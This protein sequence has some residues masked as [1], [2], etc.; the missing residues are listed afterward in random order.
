MASTAGSVTPSGAEPGRS[1]R[2]ML[3]G[4][5]V[6]FWDFDGVIKESV[7]IKSDAFERLFAS[8]GAEVA[9]RVRHHHET[10]GGVSRYEKMPLY[11]EWA[12]EAA[13]PARVDEFCSRFSTLVLQAVVDA[14]WV[15]GVR[16]YLQAQYERQRF[17]L[18]TA[19][20][21]DEI[22]QILGACG[23][24]QCFREVHGAPMKKAA[25]IRSVLDRWGQKPGEAL[26]VGDSDTE[27]AA[28]IAN[29]VPFL[30]RCTDTNRELQERFGGP[31]F[32][33]LDVAVS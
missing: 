9:A 7:T 15:P 18:I 24:A 22:E 10:H 3:T 26:V 29:D 21:Q 6:V 5:L 31:T 12:G 4:A 11:L 17:V 27:L 20:P 13:T 1:A 19:T 16:E 28:A 32:G 8:Y 30:L 33:S 14:A 23:I 2:A 25:A